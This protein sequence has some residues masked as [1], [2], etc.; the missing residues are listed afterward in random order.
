MIVNDQTYPNLCGLMST[1]AHT[2]GEDIT[3]KVVADEHRQ[4]FDVAE[5]SVGLITEEHRDILISGDQEKI[6]AFFNSA[7]W[8]KNIENCITIFVSGEEAK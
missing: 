6:D 3:P 8:F 4:N 1:I 5:E 2:V 7:S